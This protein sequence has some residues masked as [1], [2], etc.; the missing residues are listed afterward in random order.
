MSKLKKWYVRPLRKW[1]ARPVDE[2]IYAYR[3]QGWMLD[4]SRHLKDF[5]DTKI[6]RPI[7]LLGTKAGGLTFASRILRRN[8]SV[9]SVSGNSEYWSGADEMHN[10]Y[11][12]ILPKSLTGATHRMPKEDDFPSPRGWV[13]ASDPLLP[14]Y[15]NTAQ[16][17]TP[18]LKE[19]FRHLL[20]WTINRNSRGVAQPRFIDKSQLF[21][22]KL[23]Y[24]NAMVADTNPKF[25]LITRNP[26]ATC[27][28]QVRKGS[29][30]VPKYDFNE[31]L[32]LAAQHW[33]NSMKC[34]TEDSVEVDNFLTL[35]FEDILNEPV[36]HIRSICDFVELDFDDDMMPQPHHELPQGSH[37]QNWWYPIRSEVNQRY[38]DALTPEQAEVIELH[39]GEWAEKYGYLNPTRS[40]LTNS[41]SSQRTTK[42][43]QEPVH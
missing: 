20:R 39:C 27:L 38:L 4:V 6:D 41:V 9:V 13:Y 23:S 2:T 42:V 37:Y 15:R 24:I 14:L 32:A 31:K 29:V 7:F 1:A 36:T 10:V 18:E 21:T 19:E 35:R 17:V 33:M 25:L 3:R 40:T 26:Y 16:D 30:V 22:V 5:K 12:P 8:A 34:A 28:R 11:E 43:V